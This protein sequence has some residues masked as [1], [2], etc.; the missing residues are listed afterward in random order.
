MTT[1]LAIFRIRFINSLQYRIA[2]LAGLATQF[3]WGFM[4]ITAFAAFYRVNPEAFPMTFPQTASYIWLQQSMIFIFFI[5]LNDNDIIS[6]ISDGAIAYEMVRPMDIYTRWICQIAATRIAAASL[7]AFPVIAVAF[8]LPYPIGLS[9][10][11]NLF[12]FTFFIVSLLLALA[13]VV[14]FTS[15]I[16]VSLFYTMSIQGMRIMVFGFVSFLSGAIIPIPFFPEGLRAVVEL[17]PFAA[18]SNMPLRVYSGHIAGAEMFQGI[19][20]QIFWLLFL[21]I[22]G[23]IM[24]N[25]AL[26]RLVVQ[27]G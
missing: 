15:F 25:N 13:V 10:P 1:Y 24:M 23:R 9:L 21:L 11:L 4:E 18:M 12:Q 27:G 8:M 14:A 2:A 5:N 17:L 26:K 7:R 20:L 19:A 3:A 16:Y 6:G 22:L